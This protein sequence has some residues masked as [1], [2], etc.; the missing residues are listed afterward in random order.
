MAGNAFW[1]LGSGIGNLAWSSPPCLRILWVREGPSREALRPSLPTREEGDDVAT[2]HSTTTPRRRGRPPLRPEQIDRI[3]QAYEEAG[4]CEGAARKL[5]I[6]KGW[7]HTVLRRAGVAIRSRSESSRLL[8]DRIH[9]TVLREWSN[10]YSVKEV[11]RRMG[12]SPSTVREHL[13]RAEI[14]PRGDSRFLPGRGPFIRQVRESLGLTQV[15]LARRMGTVPSHISDIERGR[16]RVSRE[17]L[18][19]IAAALGCNVAKLLDE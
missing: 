12:C 8:F 13:R 2:T 11:A 9:G 6:A 4:T 10:L 18:A 16:F 3:V 17:H 7:V 5:G 1:N 19:R 15:E 14:N